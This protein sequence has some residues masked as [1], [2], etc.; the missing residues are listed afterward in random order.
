[1]ANDTLLLY[2]TFH[3]YRKLCQRRQIPI[4]KAAAGMEL[5]HPDRPEQRRLE[6]LGTFL[7]LAAAAAIACWVVFRRRLFRLRRMDLVALGVA[8]VLLGLLAVLRAGQTQPAASLGVLAPLEPRSG[9]GALESNSVV[10]R[11]GYQ[12]FAALLPSDLQASDQAEL[13]R[14]V[15]PDRLRAEVLV[16]PDGARS[17]ALH[18]PFITAVAPK[19]AVG[20]LFRD[21][22]DRG[23]LDAVLDVYRKSGAEVY[24]T[25]DDGAVVFETDGVGAVRVK[26]FHRPAP[27]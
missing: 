25:E 18:E 13:L 10:L 20:V 2:E 12:S 9:P 1:M 19:E 4:L 16:I 14:R 11:L 17:G 24:A 27:P 21:R 5:L 6:A 15:P 23:K 3:E 22:Y 26:A 7:A 8:V